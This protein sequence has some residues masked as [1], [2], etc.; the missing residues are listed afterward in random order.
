[1]AGGSLRSGTAVNI[2]DC[3]GGANQQ[4]VFAGNQ[5]KPAV[6]T[7]RSAS[8]STARCSAGR[9]ACGWPS[10]GSSTRQQWSFE[11]RNFPNP[12][13]YGHDDFIGDRVY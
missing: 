2:Y 3:H 11:S 5:I 6:A 7:R 8:P 13:G 9:R 1:M 12:V 4:F 10:C